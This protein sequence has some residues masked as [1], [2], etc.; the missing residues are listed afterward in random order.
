MDKE[1]IANARNSDLGE[2]LVNVYIGPWNDIWQQILRTYINFVQC[3][4]VKVRKKDRGCMKAI[5]V[6][7]FDGDNNWTIRVR[8]L[9][10]LQEGKCKNMYIPTNVMSM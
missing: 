9:K 4:S 6:C 7:W 3:V 5:F 1:K 8:N 2:K 10:F